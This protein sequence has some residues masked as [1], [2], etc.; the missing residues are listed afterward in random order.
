MAALHDDAL[1]AIEQ[2]RTNAEEMVTIAWGPGATSR[3]IT[4]AEMIDADLNHVRHIIE[5][6]R[7]SLRAEEP[8]L[9]FEE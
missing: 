7:D 5:L 6:H 3:R 4:M 9:E 2:V 1:A 8:E